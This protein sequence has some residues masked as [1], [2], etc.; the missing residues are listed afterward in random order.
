MYIKIFLSLYSIIYHQIILKSKNKK[1]FI[2]TC[3]Q[4]SLVSR[5]RPPRKKNRRKRQGRLFIHFMILIVLLHAYLYY[6]SLMDFLSF[7]RNIYRI[8]LVMLAPCFPTI[9]L[10]MDLQCQNHPSDILTE[11]CRFWYFSLGFFPSFCTPALVQLMPVVWVSRLM[12][13]NGCFF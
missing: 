2:V 9:S 8:K 6:S 5:Q 7:V 4:A 12:L 3:Y 1:L 11:V 10:R 13:L